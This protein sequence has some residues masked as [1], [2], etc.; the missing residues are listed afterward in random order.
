[1]SLGFRLTLRELPDGRLSLCLP[2]FQRILLAAIGLLILLAMI[3]TAPEGDK[4]LFVPANTVP[5][6]ITILS[7]LGALYQERWVFD[8]S[9]DRVVHQ[10]GVL[11]AGASRRHRISEMKAVELEQFSK[12][13]S[14][15]SQPRESVDINSPLR[16]RSP[17][18]LFFRAGQLLTLCLQGKDGSIHR[19]ET[20]TAS[21]RPRTVATARRIAEY[22]GL[23]LIG[24]TTEEIQI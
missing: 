8:R 10:F 4:R 20:Y 19:L 18:G 1:M 21:Q 3:L 15:G 9:Q 7:L 24:P 12:G 6:I 23:P 22:C 16:R 14:G 13:L 2:L 5:L 11:F 17:G